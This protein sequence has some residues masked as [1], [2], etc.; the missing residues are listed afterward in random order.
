M[1]AKWDIVAKSWWEEEL[2]SKKSKSQA[3]TKL[4]AGASFMAVGSPV[5]P[6]S[7]GPAPGG[8]AS[9]GEQV[10]AARSISA[11]GTGVLR[12]SIYERLYQDFLG[13]Q[14]KQ[15]E[16]EAAKAQARV[17][18]AAAEVAPKYVDLDPGENADR[19]R[20]RVLL[21]RKEHSQLHHSLQDLRQLE[22]EREPLLKWRPLRPTAVT[23]IPKNHPLL[24]ELD[25]LGSPSANAPA[26]RS[27]IANHNEAVVKEII[28]VLKDAKSKQKDILAGAQEID[29]YQQLKLREVR[30]QADELVDRVLHAIMEEEGLLHTELMHKTD[31][32]V[33]GGVNNGGGSK[34][35]PCARSHEG[36]PCSNSCCSAAQTCSC[37]RSYYGWSYDVSLG[38][39]VVNR[40]RTFLAK[41]GK[42][43]DLV[44]ARRQVLSDTLLLHVHNLAEA[45][46]LDIHVRDLMAELRIPR[47]HIRGFSYDLPELMKQQDWYNRLGSSTSLRNNHLINK[48]VKEI[49]HQ[50]IQDL[51]PPHLAK[52]TATQPNSPESKPKSLLESDML[53]C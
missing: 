51:V 29:V 39:L 19:Q 9:G 40:I 27:L 7:G 34:G 17:E 18:Q 35:C 21:L 24:E 53:L 47:L 20:T 50:A 2:L 12:T 3:A 5:G 4:P 10:G 46:R 1:V 33:N 23:E 30:K 15:Q 52:N 14:K 22:K 8:P 45:F 48:S 42:V 28:Q 38:P 32:P 37:P 41:S 11:T 44:A 49:L 43:E 6:A 31:Y 36:T 13:R 25:F 16:V 26:I